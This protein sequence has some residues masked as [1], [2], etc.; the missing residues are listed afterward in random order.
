MIKPKLN[1]IFNRNIQVYITSPSGDKIK[2]KIEEVSIDCYKI[3]FLPNEIGD[4]EIKFSNNE[5]NKFICHVYDTSKII[6]SDLPTAIV[7][8]LCRF[9]GKNPFFSKELFLFVDS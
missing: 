1:S 9:T 6:V 2:G 8:Q 5:E 3:D 7:N 4:Y